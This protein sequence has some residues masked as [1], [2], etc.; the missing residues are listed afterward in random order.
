MT[1]APASSQDVSLLTTAIL[2]LT[3]HIQSSSPLVEDS[4]QNKGKR[5][6]SSAP[7]AVPVKKGRQVAST[8]KVANTAQNISS[9][10]Q[11]E[12]GESSGE[13]SMSTTDKTDCQ[14]LYDAVLNDE[15]DRE[16]PTE[17]GQEGNTSESEDEALAEFVKE[18]QTDD[19]VGKGLNNGQL[20]KLVNKMVRSQL[21][22]KSLR[23]KLDN[24][25]RPS[26]CEKAKPPRVNSGIWHQLKEYT[27]KRDIRVFKLQQALDKGI[28]PIARIIDMAMSLENLDGEH[29]KQVKK[30]ALEAMSLLTHVHFELNVHRRL[31]M[32]ADI[33]KVYAPLCS[34]DVP[35][36]DFLFGDDL[37]KH[38]KDIGDQNKIGATINPSHRNSKGRGLS[39]TTYC[40]GFSQRWQPKNLQGRTAT[41]P[42]KNKA[43]RGKHNQ[44]R[45]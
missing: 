35:V 41:K 11:E 36:T 19:A 44:S 31:L 20:A 34:S 5:T 26:N 9:A 14:G 4:K 23:D 42:W 7:N 40:S 2:E 15:C 33:G 25:I 10:V 30:L 16:N 37:Q 6:A 43:S 18:Y 45:Q 1:V 22:E 13:N 24:Q 8:T 3:K 29:C 38:L 27:K 28:Y 12:L 17:N 21:G 32:K 39:N